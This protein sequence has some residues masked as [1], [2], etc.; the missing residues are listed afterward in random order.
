MVQPLAPLLALEVELVPPR[1]RTEVDEQGP[2]LNPHTVR[3]VVD[4]WSGE[5]RP[6][7]DGPHRVDPVA[8]AEPVDEVAQERAEGLGL[9]RVG[10][11]SQ[12]NDPAEPSAG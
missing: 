3:E 7:L 12:G 4:L 2:V 11:R 10:H 9:V 1:G 8:V 5:V 6:R